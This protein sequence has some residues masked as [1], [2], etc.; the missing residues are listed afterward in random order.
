MRINWFPAPIDFA[1]R[2]ITKFKH[3]SHLRLPELVK[4]N[5]MVTDEA[6]SA[7]HQLDTSA[8][9]VK[10]YREVFT[11]ENRNPHRFR[12]GFKHLSRN[13]CAACHTQD[14]AG[15]SCLQCH[16]YHATPSPLIPALSRIIPQADEPKKTGTSPVENTPPETGEGDSLI[17]GGD[18]E[19][20]SLIPGSDDEGDSLIPDTESESLIPEGGEDEGD[21]LIPADDE[22][23]ET[24]ESLIPGAEEDPLED[25][26]IPNEEESLLP[27][28][29]E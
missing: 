14:R 29:D 24:S 3:R 22:L 6:C 4:G 11:A 9:H 26:L 19:G 8:E 16:Q 18:D 7:C 17:P 25:S 23:E 27:P 13:D 5:Q 15:D 10:S 2:P 12:S 1:K 28:E 21:S 20:D